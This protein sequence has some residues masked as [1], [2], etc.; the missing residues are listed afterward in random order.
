MGIRRVVRIEVLL[1]IA[2]MITAFF[3]IQLSPK[4][5]V[6]ASVIRSDQTI[7]VEKGDTLWTIASKYTDNSKDV[8]E[9]IY[10]LK[11]INHI[12][13]SGDLQPG[14]TLQIPANLSRR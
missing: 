4:Q 14:M 12:S 9:T 2:M 5:G 11:Q 10:Q 1:A 6:I 7:Q 3:C 8:R 13:D